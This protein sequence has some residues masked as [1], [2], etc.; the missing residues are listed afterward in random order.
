[1]RGIDI[2]KKCTH[3]WI[4]PKG[5]G[6]YC[7]EAFEDYWKKNFGF[8]DLLPCTIGAAYFDQEG[9]WFEHPD[10]HMA[11]LFEHWHFWLWLS[12]PPEGCPYALEHMVNKC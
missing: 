8:T 4:V 1:M 5:S 9:A 2:C 7:E 3:D 12:E 10:S 11:E 6:P